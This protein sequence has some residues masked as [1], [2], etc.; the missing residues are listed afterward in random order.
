MLSLRTYL[1]FNNRSPFLELA[2]R[3]PSI[4]PHP[5]GPLQCLDKKTRN[6]MKCTAVRNLELGLNAQLFRK[7]IA[8]ATE[9]WQL[10]ITLFDQQGKMMTALKCSCSNGIQC[11]TYWQQHEALLS[12]SLRGIIKYIPGKQVVWFCPECPQSSFACRFP[13]PQLS[14]RR[15]SLARAVPVGSHSPA[16]APARASFQPQATLH[17]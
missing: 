2:E 3:K 15:P 12:L 8:L 1:L 9:H 10:T 4:V 17:V 6:H 16:F 7:A 11:R 13:C 5:A 14:A